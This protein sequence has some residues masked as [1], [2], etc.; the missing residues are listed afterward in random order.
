MNELKPINYNEEVVIT[1]KMLAEVYEC[2]VNNIKQNFHYAKEK[3]V[4]G[5]HYYELKG[6]DLKDF[7]RLI[8]NSNQPLYKEIKFSP[9]L[10]LWT[11]S[12]L[13]Y[14]SDAADE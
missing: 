6:N 14:T 3:F 4:E 9:K 8:E 13:L 12:C 5:K 7:K 11:K 1:T 10:Y 2:E